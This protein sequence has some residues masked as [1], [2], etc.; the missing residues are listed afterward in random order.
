MIIQNGTIELKRKTGGGIDPVTGYPSAVSYS[1][2]YPIP[3]QYIVNSHD[4]LGMTHGEHFVAAS[5]TVLVEQQA[6]DSEQLR[7]KDRAGVTVGEFSII[8]VEQLDAV[9]QTKILV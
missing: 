9:C 6:L 2:G 3:C 7:I 8:S 5:Y 1:W 4:N